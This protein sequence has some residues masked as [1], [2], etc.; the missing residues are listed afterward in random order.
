MSHNG[1]KTA[2]AITSSGLVPCGWKVLCF[3]VI[4]PIPF[5]HHVLQPIWRYASTYASIFSVLNEVLMRRDRKPIRCAAWL[6]CLWQSTTR[7]VGSPRSRC[8][9][10]SQMF[11][12]DRANIF[13]LHLR[14]VCL[15]LLAWLL[16]ECNRTMRRNLADRA[17]CPPTSNLRTFLISTSMRR[18]FD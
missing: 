13:Q 14:L 1:S 15:E 5:T 17:R 7:H 11:G 12:I 18:S 4:L 2:Q 3:A 8:V 10:K 6:W 9:T 16:P